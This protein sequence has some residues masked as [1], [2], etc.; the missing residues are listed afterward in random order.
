MNYEVMQFFGSD[1]NNCPPSDAKPAFGIVYYLV[2]N[3]PPEENDF[4]TRYNKTP[5]GLWTK[6]RR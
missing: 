2:W 6:R 1:L 4:K 5:K 3:N